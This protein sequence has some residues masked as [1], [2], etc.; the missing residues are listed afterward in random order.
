MLCKCFCVQNKIFREPLLFGL[1]FAKLKELRFVRFN[2]A[3]NYFDPMH[4][5]SAFHIY[6]NKI[7]RMRKHVKGKE[8]KLKITTSRW[9]TSIDPD[10]R[11]F[12]TKT[13]TRSTIFDFLNEIA[14]AKLDSCD[15]FYGFLIIKKSTYATEHFC[16]IVVATEL[17]E[18]LLE[19]I[20]YPRT[21]CYRSAQVSYIS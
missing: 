6:E 4:N 8:R 17:L 13:D 19:R 5:G 12:M 1:V 20:F 2:A 11:L 18:L 21:S 15:R 14:R 3:R 16:A 10:R 7:G 9:R